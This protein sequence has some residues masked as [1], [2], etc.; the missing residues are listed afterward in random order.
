[1]TE[2]PIVIGP[3][4]PIPTPPAT[5]RQQL[6]DKVSQTN[7]NYTSNLPASLIEDIVSTDVGALIIANQFLIDLINSISPYYA[8]PFILNQLGV[9]VYGIQPANATNTAV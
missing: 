1:M 9:D 8:N 4:C 6:V 5:L 7:P 2:L 3:Q